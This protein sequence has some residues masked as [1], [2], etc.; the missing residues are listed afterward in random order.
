MRFGIRWD[1]QDVVIATWHEGLP[2]RN[3]NAR[4]QERRAHVDDFDNDLEDTFEDEDNQASLNGESRFA[5]R[6]E[7]RGRGF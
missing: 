7:S 6:G 1:K 3:P 5:P 4:R 2:Q